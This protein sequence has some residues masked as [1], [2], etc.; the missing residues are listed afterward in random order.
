MRSEGGGGLCLWADPLTCPKLPCLLSTCTETDAAGSFTPSSG[1]LRKTFV[2]SLVL[3]S[4][5]VHTVN[6]TTK[7][8]TVFVITRCDNG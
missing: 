2:V 4:M 7:K 8:A 3:S 5:L 6:A 1:A